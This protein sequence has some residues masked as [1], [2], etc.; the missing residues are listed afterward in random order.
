MPSRRRRN[1]PSHDAINWP[2]GHVLER[3]MGND[4]GWWRVRDDSQFSCFHLFPFP[5]L[6][7]S[8]GFSVCRRPL[9][10]RVLEQAVE[11]GK[12][13]GAIPFLEFHDPRPDGG[14]PPVGAGGKLYLVMNL[15][16]G[17]LSAL[18]KSN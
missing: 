15:W 12:R 11:C 9:Q 17:G 1:G 6:R 5:V 2:R 4:L 14:R 3:S 7:M 18:D 16:S 8:E 10:Q 13:F